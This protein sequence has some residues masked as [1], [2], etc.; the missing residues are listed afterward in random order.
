MWGHDC[1]EDGATYPTVVFQG[2]AC[3]VGIRRLNE[4]K[5]VFPH[6]V[7]DSLRQNPLA[8]GTRLQEAVG[9]RHVVPRR[10]DRLHV[11]IAGEE[12]NDAI[13]N[14]LAVLNEDAPEIPHHGR[15]IPNFKAGAN[16]NLIAPSRYDLT[17]IVNTCF[18]KSTAC[19]GARHSPVVEKRY[20]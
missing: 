10:H 5:L 6:L 18:C 11:Q 12:G 1:V 7:Q 20:G 8:D 16:G 15:V 3:L 9:S 19:V 13:R 2:N 17:H 4:D 14:N